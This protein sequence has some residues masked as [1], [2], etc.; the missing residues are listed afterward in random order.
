MPR[1]EDFQAQR[2]NTVNRLQE[3]TTTSNLQM[4]LVIEMVADH[5]EPLL[6][7]A[8]SAT[9]ERDIGYTFDEKE[10]PP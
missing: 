3:A 6:T 9:L 10:V 7:Q 4:P 1:R 2:G 5:V 8:D